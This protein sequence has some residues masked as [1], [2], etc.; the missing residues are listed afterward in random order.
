MLNGKAMPDCLPVHASLDDLQG[1]LDSLVDDR[2]KANQIATSRV[3]VF[4][5]D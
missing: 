1:W 2:P 5:R 4:G 3:I